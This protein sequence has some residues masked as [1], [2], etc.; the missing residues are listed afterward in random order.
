MM[1]TLREPQRVFVSQFASPIGTLWLAA[2]EL[3]LMKIAFDGEE[4]RGLEWVLKKFPNARLVPGEKNNAEF[5][6]ELDEYFQGT[7]RDFTCKTA[8]AV[9]EFSRI[10]LREVCRIPFGATAGYRDIARA[11]G[12][13]TA[14]RAVGRALAGNPVPVIVPCHRV[15]GSDGKL[16]GFGG[17]LHIKQWLLSHERGYLH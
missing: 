14:P 9:S 13:P 6:I 2:T 16:V 11:I 3:G 1:F 7:R 5:H 8:L 17:G 4:E 12:M 10:V 15:V